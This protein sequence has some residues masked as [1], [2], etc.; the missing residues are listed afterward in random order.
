MLDVCSWIGRR[1][2]ASWSD[3]LM[4]SRD[5]TE[6]ALYFQFLEMIGE[7]EKLYILRGPNHVLD[8]ERSVWHETSW[9]KRWRVYDREHFTGSV[10]NRRKGS[11][12]AIQSWLASERWLPKGYTIE[13][14][15]RALGSWILGPEEVALRDVECA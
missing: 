2:G 11:F 10:D 13:E 4:A 15:Y 7:M 12:V 3:V 8:L 14:F 6:Y 9:Y 1:G 5:W